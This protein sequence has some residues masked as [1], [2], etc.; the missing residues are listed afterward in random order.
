MLSLFMSIAGGVSWEEVI[1]PL[2]EILGMQTLIDLL[3]SHPLPRSTNIY[4]YIYIN[5]IY[6]DIFNYAH[7]HVNHMNVYRFS[8]DSM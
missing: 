5:V 2:Q 7:M 3:E 6:I 8:S 1:R 4:I